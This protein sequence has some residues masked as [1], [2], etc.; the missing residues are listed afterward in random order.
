MSLP[1]SSHSP[2][3]ATP[4]KPVSIALIGAGSIGKRHLAA[5]KASTRCH[6][7]AIADNN[8]AS[9]QVAQHEAVP[10][11]D[12]Y[13]SL[14]QTIKPDG[15]IVA[16]PTEHH[17][18][19]TVA[20]L[21]ASVHV[22]V[23][24]PVMATLDE[25]QQVI[26]LSTETGYSVLVGHHRRY[27]E[28]VEKA[29]AIIEDGTIGQLV[30]VVGQWTMRKHDDYYDSAWR[31]QWQAGPILTNLIH[32]MDSLRYLCGEV[33]EV[34]AR[35]N[36]QV[37]GHEKE[38]TAAAIITFASGVLGTFLLSDQTASPWSWERATGENAAFPATAQNAV[39]FM[40]TKGS[41]EFPNLT[42]WHHDGTPADWLHPM[43]SMHIATELEDAYI[44][45][46]DHFADV[47]LGRAEPRASA[48]DAT[49]TLKA[50][51]AVLESSQHAQPVRLS[52]RPL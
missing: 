22:L 15:V 32:D 21:Q 47:I 45:Q 17:L 39:K 43:Q 18:Q 1:T 34:V 29:K 25:A 42:L 8:P 37:L 6:L 48:V 24:K 33:S 35:A 46:V 40:G 27:Y 49:E 12:H 30:A 20:A 26:N 2:N 16:T 36:N 11:F 51:L 28:R 3:N 10:F 4:T 23:E 19:P 13:D 31:R 44:K 38:D 52:G 50:T 9:A 14:L 7:V 5:L 41:L